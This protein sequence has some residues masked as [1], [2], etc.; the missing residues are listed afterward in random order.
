MGCAPSQ[1]AKTN[2]IINMNKEKEGSDL[3]KTLEFHNVK[4]IRIQ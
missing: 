4:I 2:S 1:K 3:A